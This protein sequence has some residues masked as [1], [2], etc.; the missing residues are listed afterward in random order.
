MSDNC[1]SGPPRF[2][3]RRDIVPPFRGALQ[4]NTSPADQGAKRLPF[5]SPMRVFS[6][7]IECARLPLPVELRHGSK[8]APLPLRPAKQTFADEIGVSVEGY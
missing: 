7:W 2:R 8:V 3:S 4:P 6:G 5:G 1:L